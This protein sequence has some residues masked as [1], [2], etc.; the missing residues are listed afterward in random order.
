MSLRLPLA[1]IAAAAL[2]VL[3]GDTS[4]LTCQ[5]AA[6]PCAPPP[7]RAG[8]RAMGD[9]DSDDGA[10]KLPRGR[11]YALGPPR[12]PPPVLDY[13]GLA[14]H[15]Y[16]DGSEYA[17]DWVRGMRSGWGVFTTPDGCRY[18]GEWLTDRHD[19]LGVAKYPSG[20]RYEGEFRRNTRHGRGLFLWK[21]SVRGHPGARQRR[22]SRANSGCKRRASPA[23]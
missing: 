20:N 5:Y 14:V 21:N 4:S 2:S 16:E 12:A 9:S 22:A 6:A 8:G 19:G 17:G 15:R 23:S 10:L 11:P 7:A 1:F 18:A 3:K 13:A